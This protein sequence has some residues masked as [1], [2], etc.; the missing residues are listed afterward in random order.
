[1][2]KFSFKKK[3]IFFLSD[4]IKKYLFTKLTKQAL[5]L[6]IKGNDSIASSSMASGC[7]EEYLVEF[8]KNSAK[9]GM[10][11]FFID[12]G[13]N[14]GLISCQLNNSF[15]EFHMY[16]PN[17]VLSKILEAN[18]SSTF[19]NN[20]MIHTIGLGPADGKFKLNVPKLNWGGAFIDDETNSYNKEI[21]AIKDGFKK[22]DTKN[23]FM[24]DIQVNDVFYEMSSLFKY[25]SEKGLSKGCFKIDVEGYEEAIINGIIKTIPDNFE[26]I[27]VCECW[28]RKKFFEKL[29]LDGLDTRRI[30]C[31]ELI[32]KKNWVLN[33]KWVKAIQILMRGYYEYFY[34]PIDGNIEDNTSGDIVITIKPIES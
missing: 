27:I 17:P 31:G 10:N 19:D 8:F 26:A 12:I 24:L 9:D 1:M 21:L 28:D 11:E 22:F 29:N 33:F 6:F 20:F 25:L 16:E 5:P 23:Y 13:A 3:A 2:K 4:V 30:E 7:Y 14:I 32:I 18:A 15:N 34:Q